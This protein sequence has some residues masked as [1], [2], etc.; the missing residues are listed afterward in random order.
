MRRAVNLITV[1]A[2]VVLITAAF[3]LGS[4]FNA[5]PAAASQ[6]EG[7]MGKRFSVIEHAK[8]TQFD[9]GTPGASVG[10]VGVF[11]ND[12]YDADNAKVVGTDQGWC[13]TTVV[14]QRTECV[15][16]FIFVDGSIT[17]AG[18]VDAAVWGS[19]EISVAVTGGTGAY[20]GATGEARVKRVPDQ[21]HQFAFAFDLT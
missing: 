12:L 2:V 1:S 17:T 5:A 19:A 20:R 7:A 3:V 16:S 4:R 15:A 10:D 8:P 13:V 21:E 11:S 6:S 9:I 18:A 14:G